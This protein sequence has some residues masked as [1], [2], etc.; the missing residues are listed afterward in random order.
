MTPRG[1]FD[2]P[3]VYCGVCHKPA[4]I[5]EPL[6]LTSCAH[7]LCL[8]HLSDTVCTLCGTRDILVIKLVESKQLPEDIRILFEPIP[9]VLENLYNVS[10]FQITGLVNQ[11]QYYQEHCI[12][13]QEKCARQRKLLYQAKGELDAVAKL[14][15]RI[16]E[17]EAVLGK[18]R[19]A[20]IDSHSSGSSVF[21]VIKPP[22]TVDLTAEDNEQTFLKKLKTSSSLRNKLQHRHHSPSTRRASTSVLDWQFS[23][24]KAIAES[25]QLGSFLSTPDSFSGE[26]YR[27]SPTID[28]PPTSLTAI[29]AG[30]NNTRNEELKKVQSKFPSALEKLRIVKRN[31]TITNAAGS[32]SRGSQGLTPQMRSSNGVQT[33]TGLLMR[34]NTSGQ[35]AVS[36]EGPATKGTNNKFRRIR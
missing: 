15:S 20:M 35:N 24:N 34:R 23:D 1:L 22:D 19:N 14:K 33:Q 27:S 36:S 28:P 12:K 2:Q 8:Q 11:C 30:E 29:G 32:R 18:R 31:H 17:L 9:A 16:A 25:T 7:T 4:T 13:L 3:F 10:Q 26:K 6:Y 21:T 5:E